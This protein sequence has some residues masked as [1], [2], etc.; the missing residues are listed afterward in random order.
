MK[1]NQTISEKGRYLY[2][3][4][5][6]F[7]ENKNFLV[8]L[9]DFVNL[10][11]SIFQIQN[12]LQV[13]HSELTHAESLQKDMISRIEQ[14]RSSVEATVDS[15]HK[16]YNEK[17]A[18]ARFS[19]PA[20]VAS[21]SNDGG[22]TN[23]F[24]TT[25]SSLND[26]L[27][28]A[29][30]KYTRRTD[31]Y[32]QHLRSKIADSKQEAIRLLQDW[33]SNDHYGLPYSLTS[34]LLTKVQV[35]IDNI[36]TTKH[37][38]IT[39]TSTIGNSQH[40][41]DDSNAS[42][43]NSGSTFPSM[44]YS[45]ALSSSNIDFWNYRRKVSEIDV[46]EI[47]IPFG[48]R[49]PITEK[50]KQSFRI[51]PGLSKELIEKEPGFVNVDNYYIV[52]ASLDD[53][54]ETL[55]V[56]LANNPLELDYNVI[57]ISYEISQLQSEKTS[58]ERYAEGK[59]PKIDC[60]IKEGAVQ[61]V[62]QIK[63]I[64]ES[65]D[66]SKIILFG[67]ALMDKMM[68]LSDPSIWPLRSKL[69]QIRLDSKGAVSVPIG[70]DSL[71]INRSIHY[72]PELVTIFLETIAKSFTPLVRKFKEKSAVAGEL[73]LRYERENGSRE[74]YTAKIEELNSLL[75]ATD[76]GKKISDLL[77][78]SSPNNNVNIREGGSSS[79]SPTAEVP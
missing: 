76:N 23:L 71:S 79:S 6:P 42:S 49:T 2:P 43:R 50:I 56:L 27:T 33:L 31:E 14:F 73:I 19:L 70:S 46:K 17:I 10:S 40:K 44:S 52:S 32:N 72:D 24:L 29:T 67:R 51:I 25:K 16:E 75:S 8:M 47:L 20:A 22:D 35:S 64:A 12:D 9:K 41:N 26:V 36:P 21:G 57:R 30:E 63:E 62:L 39:K 53:K 5:S 74:E 59:L 37:Y 34:N 61:D 54:D 60:T 69:V 4:Y 68:L 48:L 45:L 3:D 55:S 58:A 1:P 13:F 28:N 66:I 18:N 77:L 15:F 38:T 65:T 7:E 11:C 78:L